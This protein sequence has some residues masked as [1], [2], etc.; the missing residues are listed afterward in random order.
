MTKPFFAIAALGASSLCC[1]CA[2][3]PPP[4]PD[5]VQLE[6]ALSAMKARDEGRSARLQEKVAAAD[7]ISSTVLRAAPDRL[8]PD[9]AIALLR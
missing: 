4:S 3:G 8:D 6:R 2:K 1:A 7:R 5:P 9:V